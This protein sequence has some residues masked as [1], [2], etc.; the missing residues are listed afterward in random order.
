[1][2]RNIVLFT[3]LTYVSGM[4]MRET[5]ERMVMVRTSGS[6]LQPAATGYIYK[7]NSDGL[8]R[9]EKMG[10]SEVMETLSKLYKEP[11]A[12]TAPGAKSPF[13]G[14]ADDENKAASHASEAYIK[15]VVEKSEEEDDHVDGIADEDYKKIFEEYTAGFGPYSKKGYSDYY[16]G[17]GHY[18]DDHYHENGG[19]KEFG[20]KGYH[21]Y[22]DKGHKGFTIIHHYGKGDDG[23]YHK[24][25][26]D[27]FAVS[28]KGGHSKKYDEADEHGKSY[29]EGH[30]YKGG[31][32]GH[33]GGH[34]KGETVEGFHKIY[35]KNEFKKDHDFYGGEKNEGSQH[36]HDE[37]HVFHGSDAGGFKKGDSHKS[38][39]GK[40]AY[41]KGGH[42]EKESGE[43]HGAGHSEK[44]EGESFKHGEGESGAKGGKY[45][46]K[47]YGYE[48]KH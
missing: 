36:K 42:G 29:A 18:D 6:D 39:Y 22:G 43:E 13:Y 10:E 37:G 16:R 5:V 25:G 30:H 46:G 28:N 44:G 34:S 31:D 20:A 24:E 32:H 9:V 26:H 12:Y 38:G 40:A 8:A 3:L 4:E 7:K 48:I 21:G 41:G 19:G 47:S 2:A 35:D 17:L 1:M 33:K 14:K 23:D 15:P 27:S 45:H 11:H